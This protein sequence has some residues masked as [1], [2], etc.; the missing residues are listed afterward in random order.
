[1][2]NYGGS[3]FDSTVTT[4]PD[5]ITLINNLA[6]DP[7]AGSQQ[8]SYVFPPFAINSSSRNNLSTDDRG[9]TSANPT[10]ASPGGGGVGNVGITDNPTCLDPEGCVYFESCP[11][12]ATTDCMAMG[13]AGVY[14]LHLRTSA[15]NKAVD[16]G[17]NLSSI[18]ALDIDAAIR[19]TPWDIGADDL[20]ATTVVKL[21]SFDARGLDSAVEVSWQTASELDNLGFHLYRSSSADGP[22]T[23]LTSSLIPGLGSSAVGQA[24]SFRDTGLVN[25]TQ[26]FYRLED[27]DASSKTTSHGPVSAVPQA[28]AASEEPAERGERKRK[29]FAGTD[30]PAWVLA[31]YT[32]SSGATSAASLRCT[33]RGDPEAVSLAVVSRDARQATLELRTGGFYAL[34]EPAGTVRVFIPGF[35]FP[36]DPQAPALPLRRAFVDAVVGRR[37]KL[38]GVRALDLVAFPGL[39][40]SA[41]G[42]AEMQVS[43]DG[44]V[45]AARRAGRTPERFPQ[46]ELV[47]LLPSVFQ[48][49]TKSAVVELSPVRFD[50]QRRQLVLARTIRVRLLFTGRE[51]GESGKG[52]RGRGPGPRQTVLDEILARL[53]TT[54]RGLHAASFELLFPG[55]G[56]GLA[57]SQLRLQRQGEAVPFHVEPDGD[58][59]GPGGRLFFFANTVAASTSFSPEVAWEFV[60]SSE[61]RQMARASAQPSGDSL[62]AASVGSASFEVNRFY[63]PGLLDAPDPWLWEALA[64]GVTR[65]QTFSLTGAEGASSQS[66]ELTLPAGSVGIRPGGG[67]PRERVAE[68]LAPGRS[69]VRGQAPLPGEP[70]P[71]R[72]A[73]ARRSERSRDHQRRRHRRRFVRLPRPLLRR[74]PAAIG[75][76]SGDASRVLGP[77]A[78]S[79]PWLR[80]PRRW[81]SSS[82]RRQKRWAAQRAT[83]SG[84]R[85]TR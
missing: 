11:V 26:Y 70:Q 33:R 68:R 40:P 52:H 45:R 30:C 74:L 2:Y 71:P 53:Y 9:V 55:Q 31:A 60:R 6:A 16:A 83:P 64:G 75:R 17:A 20:A 3:A 59:F 49:D 82:W 8:P 36:Q 57:L 21:Q 43:R 41:V 76:R 63:Q 54:S 25:G 24:Y 44:T 73:P 18:F 56:R 65:T 79:R 48:G 7:G 22:W 80:T 38:A 50:A 62:S 10:C 34:H 1:M 81:R 13:G 69:P 37:V 85:D 19:Q 66:A 32:A 47:R 39:N 58:S 5:R 72:V 84:S 29:G 42:S 15:S 28:A 12:Q 23:R 4:L 61:G 35:D 14:N 78:E 27:V 67:S 77:R 46:G 51:A